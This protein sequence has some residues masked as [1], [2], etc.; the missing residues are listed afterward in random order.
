[1]DAVLLAGLLDRA[2]IELAVHHHEV[3]ID[4]LGRLRQ[5]LP[6]DLIL[7]LPAHARDGIK[8]E[9]HIHPDYFEHR[10][11]VV[12]APVLVAENIV[13]VVLDVA[14]ERCVTIHSKL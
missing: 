4:H 12:V 6:N 13:L 5:E 8:D 14:S 3:E 10:P 11:L 1:M 2:A 7:R 9:W